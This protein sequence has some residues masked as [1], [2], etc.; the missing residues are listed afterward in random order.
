MLF[1][2]ECLLLA[3]REFGR[4]YPW[5]G[6]VRYCGGMPDVPGLWHDTEAANDAAFRPSQR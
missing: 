1:I 6:R 3:A 5:A 4:L 2:R